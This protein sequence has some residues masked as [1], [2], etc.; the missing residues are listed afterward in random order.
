M[1]K[2]DIYKNFGVTWI[3][4]SVYNA[5]EREIMSVNNP[6]GLFYRKRFKAHVIEPYE[7]YTGITELDAALREHA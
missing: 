6:Y 1:K 2:G 5:S 3:V 7:G 4:D